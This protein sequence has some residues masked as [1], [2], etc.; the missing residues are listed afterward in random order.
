MD[1]EGHEFVTNE[2]IKAV[3][4][5]L[6]PTLKWVRPFL[7][8]SM[9]ASVY[10]DSEDIVTLGHLRDS[11]QKHHFMRYGGQTPQTPLDAY[12]VAV[13]WI[14]DN[15]YT[16]VNHLR[17]VWQNPRHYLHVHPVIS[18]GHSATLCI[19][20]RI[21]IPKVMSA[22]RKW[23]HFT[24]L[25]LYKKHRVLDTKWKTDDLGKEAI[26]AGRELI[27]IVVESSKMKMD[28]AVP[29]R[30]KSLWGTFVSVCL[31]QDLSSVAR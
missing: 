20:F 14:H 26:V 11:G 30:W 24:P 15:A 9:I 25:A 29:L 13:D 28:A 18:A 27:K 8:D 31:K 10:R 17:N 22:A 23:A 21:V 1:F 3:V 4:R 12:N 16:A 5:Q 2:S 19:H 7:A 6:P